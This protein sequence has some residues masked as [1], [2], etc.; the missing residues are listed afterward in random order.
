MATRGKMTNKDFCWLPSNI[1]LHGE[2]LL[3]YGYDT[4]DI[5]AAY[6]ADGIEK[7]GD[8]FNFDLYDS[9][10]PIPAAQW[11]PHNME[12]LYPFHM[13]SS[14]FPLTVL[15]SYAAQ[16]QL[17]RASWLQLFAKTIAQHNLK[18]KNYSP[19]LNNPVAVVKLG[20]RIAKIA[21][22]RIGF[23]SYEFA[24]ALIFIGIGAI[25]LSAQKRCVMCFRNTAMGLRYC[26]NHSQSKYLRDSFHDDL[27]KQSQRARTGRLANKKLGWNLSFPY[28][29]SLHPLEPAVIAGILWASNQKNKQLR[30]SILDSL[31]LAPLVVEK[32]P[33]D[34]LDLDLNQIICALRHALDPNQWREPSWPETIEHA[35]NWFEAEIAVAPGKP[36]TGLRSKNVARLEK[37][38]KWKAEGMAQ[39]EIAK[40][41][42]ITPSHL[43]KIIS[44]YQ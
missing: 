3:I 5:A 35:Q 31:E 11:S 9:L 39:K 13:D 37:A 42:E 32:L 30:K 8:D 23:Q 25:A 38:L 21:G 44:K 16:L 27:V 18:A 15:V 26:A 20:Q 17:D 28:S 12:K 7:I 10:L 33:T 24:Q 19:S 34:F 43:S 6:Q 41:L 36:P 1:P 22:R 4:L 29:F 14:F 40:R 2:E